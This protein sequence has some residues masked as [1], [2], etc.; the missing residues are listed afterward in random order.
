[1]GVIMGVRKCAERRSAWKKQLAPR[2]DVW[3]LPDDQIVALDA[4]MLLGILHK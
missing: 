4:R 2:M 1:M 3:R